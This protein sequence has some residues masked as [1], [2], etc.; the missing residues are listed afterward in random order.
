MGMSRYECVT[1]LR[2]S[3]FGEILLCR[4]RQTQEEVV[5]K[6][7]DLN[8]AL[9]QESKQYGRVQEN[10]LKEIEVMTQLCA[11][12]GHPNVINMHDYYVAGSNNTLHVVLDYCEGGDLLESC[13][14]A[15]S[16]VAINQSARIDQDT[17]M[18]YLRD[19]VS[20][21]GFLHKNGIAH[22]DLSLENILLHNGRA[23]IADFGLCA[24]QEPNEKSFRRSEIVGKH[25]YMAPEIVAEAD[26]DP[27]KADIWSVGISFFILLTSS[28]PFEMASTKDPGFRYVAKNGLKAVFKAWDL[29]ETIS[30]ATQDLLERMT[31]IDPQRRPSIEEILDHPAIAEISRPSS[32]VPASTV[33]ST[34]AA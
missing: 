16:P 21:L 5:V 27:K 29:G 32:R 19:V 28:P 10:V 18:G 23:V 6:T 11:A 17:A 1:S 25:Y 8:L 24:Q 9:K 20:G 4:D 33:I 14:P 12:G 22:R 34:E 7:V 30:G 31:A 13:M 2:P 15:K 26:Y 3:I